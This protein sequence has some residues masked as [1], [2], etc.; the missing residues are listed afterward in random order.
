MVAVRDCFA[1]L[2]QGP[3]N[4]PP[5]YRPTEPLQPA[6]QK[7]C[8]KITQMNQPPLAAAEQQ[9]ISQQVDTIG[10]AQYTPPPPLRW[11]ELYRY[12]VIRSVDYSETKRVPISIP[13]HVSFLPYSPPRKSYTIFLIPHH[14]ITIGA[15][16]HLAVEDVIIQAFKTKVSR[17]VPSA[18]YGTRPTENRMEWNGIENNRIGFEWNTTLSPTHLPA[19]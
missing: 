16:T 13:N 9:A 15:E 8:T 17:V 10:G 2:F 1:S 19:K 4:R 12:D 18:T 3:L 5:T 6:N 14:N 7:K 11:T